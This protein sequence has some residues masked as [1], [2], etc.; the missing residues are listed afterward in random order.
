LA[1]RSALSQSGTSSVIR[2]ADS[3]AICSCRSDRLKRRS[4]HH[5][6]R[7]GAAATSE[8]SDNRRAPTRDTQP[9]DA[10]RA[11]TP[12]HLPDLPYSA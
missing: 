6:F 2:R 9:I 8:P 12:K 3:T 4:L 1:Y 5:Q 7:N 10:L 11:L